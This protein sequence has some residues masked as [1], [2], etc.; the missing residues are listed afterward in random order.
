VTI[1]ATPPTGEVSASAPVPLNFSTQPL[2]T[3]SAPL[4]LN[5]TNIASGPLQLSSLAFTGADPEDFV[6]TSDG[7]LGPIPAGETCTLEVAFA[8]QGPGA[9]TATLVIGSNDQFS[10]AFVAV[11]GTGGQLPQGPA[12]ATGATGTTGTAGAAGASGSHGSPGEVE[13]VTCKVVTKKVTRKIHGKRR[14]V[15]VKRQVCTAKLVPGPVKFTA[16]ATR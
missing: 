10:P 6:V 11:S 2:Q 16:A 3:I 1:A 8:P 4:A 13:L 12:G 14:K 9:R 15:K 7:C 5:I